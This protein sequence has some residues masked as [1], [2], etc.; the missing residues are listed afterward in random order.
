MAMASHP[1][2]HP[3]TGT[4]PSLSG[5]SPIISSTRRA[6]LSG[7]PP[8]P[9]TPAVLGTAGLGRSHPGEWLHLSL[10]CGRT[11]VVSPTAVGG[12]RTAAL[13]HLWVLPRPL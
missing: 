7:L 10:L 6:A 11:L 9:I 13:T 5:Q 3:G 12:S 4:V 8:G 2:H 1:S